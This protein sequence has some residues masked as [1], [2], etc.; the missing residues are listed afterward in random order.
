MAVNPRLTWT[1]KFAVFRTDSMTRA[2]IRQEEEPITMDAIAEGSEE[3]FKNKRHLYGVKAS[4][5]VGF[6]FWQDGCLITLT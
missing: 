5:N 1:E 4:R 2:F 3:E 6:G